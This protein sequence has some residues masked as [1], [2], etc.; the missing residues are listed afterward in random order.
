MTVDTIERAKALVDE[1]ESRHCFV[2]SVWE[3]INVMSGNKLYAVFIRDQH[4]DIYESPYV[5]KPVRIWRG[6]YW[7][8]DYEYLNNED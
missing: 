4:C 2:G 6:G 5:T 3:Y 8:G 1:M 7:L